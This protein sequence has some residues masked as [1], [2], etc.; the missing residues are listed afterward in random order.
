[1]LK[2]RRDKRFAVLLV[3]LLMLMSMISVLPV[4][5]AQPPQ[6]LSPEELRARGYASDRT[7]YWYSLKDNI[8]AVSGDI[9]ISVEN[10]DGNDQ[11]VTFYG[12]AQINLNYGGTYKYAEFIAAI[13]NYSGVPY[14]CYG[15]MLDGHGTEY[16]DQRNDLLHWSIEDKGNGKVKAVLKDGSGNVV[17]SREATVGSGAMN[18]A[19]V[20]TS[21]E[22]Y[23]AS[24]GQ[25]LP[26]KLEADPWHKSV[27]YHDGTIGN[28]KNAV[29]SQG[30]NGDSTYTKIVHHTGSTYY[31]DWAEGGTDL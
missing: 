18:I 2:I 22:F 8:A 10:W 14:H 3:C 23:Y 7:D 21:A 9:D 5:S 6:P 28:F 27:R 20:V 24:S 15:I 25:G 29:K 17:L 26:K 31:Y 13:Y 11:D 19:G 1:M 30:Y 4:I 12:E 16:T